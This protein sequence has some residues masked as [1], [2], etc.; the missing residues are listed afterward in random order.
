[1]KI[2]RMT[3]LKI[4]YFL[5]TPLVINPQSYYYNLLLTIEAHGIREISL[6]QHSKATSHK[7]LLYVCQNQ[8]TAI[9]FLLILERS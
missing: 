9:Y 1:M 8:N 3:V 2:P 6:P 4:P 5:I 7:F